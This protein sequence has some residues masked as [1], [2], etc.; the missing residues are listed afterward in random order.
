M[1]SAFSLSDP[2]H[3]KTVAVRVVRW[4]LHDMKIVPWFASLIGSYAG[5][6]LGER[7]GMFAGIMLSIVGAGVGMYYG[8][9]WAMEHL[10]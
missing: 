10:A 4:H 6:F 3:P 7:F 5:W 9:K 1:P 2:F 8:R